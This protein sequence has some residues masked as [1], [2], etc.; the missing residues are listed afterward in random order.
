MR[1]AR[2]A[3]TA[4]ALAAAAASTHLITPICPEV[5]DTPDGTRIR[6][7]KIGH[8]DATDLPTPDRRHG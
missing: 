8:Y 6:I 7:P 4:A 3:D 5:Y 1:L 2:S